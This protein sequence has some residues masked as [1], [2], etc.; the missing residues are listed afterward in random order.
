MRQTFMLLACA[1]AVPAAAQDT[2]SAMFPGGSG[3]YSREYAATHLARHPDQRVTRI[4]L[5]P[6]PDQT[7]VEQIALRVS[8]TLRD[9][10]EQFQGVAYCRPTGPSLSCAVE[11]DGGSFAITQG[12]SG[13]LLTLDRDGLSMEGETAFVT[14]SGT[15]GDDRSF[16][17]PAI[18]AGNC[19]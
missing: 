9:S 18:A 11:G 14:L 17:L 15:S 3:C 1:A 10:P 6:D 19:P 12:D 4:T 16:S 13:L 8:V 2:R 7:T 5:Y